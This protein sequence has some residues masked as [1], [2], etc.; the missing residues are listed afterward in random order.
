MSIPTWKDNLNAMDTSKGVS[1]TMIQKSMIKEIMA[2]RKALRGADASKLN[3]KTNRDFWKQQ[4]KKYQ[5][6]LVERKI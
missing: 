1:N 4:A 3:V 2:L 5:R 6:M